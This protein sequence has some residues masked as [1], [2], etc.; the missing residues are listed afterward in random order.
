MNRVLLLISTRKMHGNEILGH[1]LQFDIDRHD[2]KKYSS[3]VKGL[4]LSICKEV[5][6]CTIMIKKLTATS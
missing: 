4:L 3:I 6:G 2:I 5:E 1:I